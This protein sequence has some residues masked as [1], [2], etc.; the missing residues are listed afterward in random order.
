MKEIK[1]S[2]TLCTVVTDLVNKTPVLDIHT[3][4]YEESFGDLL[5]RGPE[6]LITYHYLQAETNRVLTDMTPAQLMAMNTPDQARL[7]WQKLFVERSPIS[8][9]TRGVVTAWKRLGAPNVRDYDGVLKFFSSMSAAQ[10]IDHVFKTANVS[11]VVM[12]N[13]PFVPA[14]QAVW[15]S[16]KRHDARF[17]AALRIDSVLLDWYA[18][19]QKVQQAGYK[20][21]RDLSESTFPEIARFLKDWAAKMKPMYMAASLPPTFMMPDD[22]P[23]GRIL[24]QAVLP[25]C[26]DLGIPFAMMIG[27]KKRVMPELGDAGDAQGRANL[28]SVG[29]LCRAFPHN[30]FLLTMLARENHHEAMVLARKFRN[31]HVFGCWW[32]NNNPSIVEE[33]TRARIELLGLSMTPQH[34]DARVLDQLVYKWTHSRKVI[35][36]VLCEK[37]GYLI[38]EGWFPSEDEIARDVSLLLGGEFLRFVG[39]K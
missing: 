37:Y 30:K 9:A 2:T 23:T 12:T 34:S 10:M 39:K 15:N 18:F 28:D 22:S 20:V 26:R 3:H 33:M 27:V 13:D 35:A 16:G 24:A 19:W 14:E 7:V 1:D 8:E 21:D 29:Y 11:A 32:F 25:A 17:H 4:I 5:L 31:L 6:A 36:G 38:D